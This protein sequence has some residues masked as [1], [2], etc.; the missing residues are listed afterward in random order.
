MPRYDRI[1]NVPYVSGRCQ[2]FSNVGAHS[3]LQRLMGRVREGLGIRAALR[4]LV[5]KGPPPARTTET[6]GEP[7][8]FREGDVVRVRDR[9]SIRRTLDPNDK[10]RGLHFGPQQWQSCGRTY[11]VTK[12]MRRLIDDCGTMRRVSR[13]VLLDGV[14][15]T[16]PGGNGGCGRDCPMMYRDEWLE[17]AESALQD[18][19]PSCPTPNAHVRLMRVR[20]PAS[21]EQTLDVFGRCDGLLFM[22]EMAKYAGE[23]LR[24]T[25]QL[26]R[27]WELSRWVP[28]RDPIY[29]SDAS[30]TGAVL[31]ANGPCDRACALLWHERWL[32]PI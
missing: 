29:V 16:M 24:L 18:D 7:S 6:L 4:R 22:P 8:C 23:I 17:L 26:D 31:G 27:V 13:T 10:L 2:R 30:C 14:P 20:D 3:P 11:R 9:S 21:I 19:G 1:P 28:V 15:C 5:G 25:R 32:E 12:V